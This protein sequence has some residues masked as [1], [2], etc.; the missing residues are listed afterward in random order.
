MA[1][2]GF[3]KS[4]TTFF[5]SGLM[6]AMSFVAMIV[7]LGMYHVAQIGAA[8]G[9]RRSLIV[10]G[11][12]IGS[13]A[14]LGVI[15]GE[16]LF[17][18]SALTGAAWLPGFVS[19]LVL[20]AQGGRGSLAVATMIMLL[21]PV[22]IIMF[23]LAP[24]QV[25]DFSLV[26]EEMKSAIAEGARIA[27]SVQ[28]A[29]N[30]KSM[31][32]LLEA[33]RKSTEFV[34]LK[35]LF[36]SPW[37]ARL[38]W[39]VYGSGAPW[40]FG[41]T[42][43]AIGNLVLLDI[44]F[45]QIE[46]LVAVSRYIDQNPERFSEP[47]RIASGSLKT[48]ITGNL[49]QQY[50]VTALRHSGAESEKSGS[51]SLLR[52]FR[53]ERKPNEIRVMGFQ[54]TLQPT[55]TSTAWR[56]REWRMPLW[57]SF[58]FVAVLLA[59]GFAQVAVGPKGFLLAADTIVSQAG[60]GA[61]SLQPFIALAA[62][63]GFVGGCLVATEGVITLLQLLSP[64]GALILLLAFILGG[65]LVAANPLLVIAVLGTAGL[66]DHLYDLRKLNKT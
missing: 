20:R 2:R 42:M 62:L 64:I 44:A 51:P 58:S 38:L 4:R 45:E 34:A 22:G 25:A 47:L 31:T 8:A 40:L 37:H 17:L 60:A 56:L 12:V 57:L 23:M 33:F 16:H 29:E 66:L 41:L 18:L 49:K 53:N 19:G 61:L 39:L 54:F 6:I 28:S 21:V 48:S 1:T 50:E 52:F 5:L 36:E 10:L 13:L 65:S 3:D 35:S 11:S 59:C 27:G 7:P 55:E 46:R 14:F 26:F 30:A 15:S 43:M 63:I 9:R 24:A 32:D